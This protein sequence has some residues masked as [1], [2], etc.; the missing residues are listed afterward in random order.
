MAKVLQ[1]AGGVFG[2]IAAALWFWSA[3][4]RLPRAVTYF[5]YTPDDDPRERAIRFSAR[6][7]AWAAFFTGL[8][9]A[10]TGASAFC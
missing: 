2:L 5:D 8:S 1:L 3:A 9:A 4:R 6:L 10:L 7:N